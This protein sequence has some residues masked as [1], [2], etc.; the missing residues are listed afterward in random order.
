RAII[1]LG[2]D[3]YAQFQ[4]SMLGRDRF[5]PFTDLL[6][7]KGWASEDVTLNAFPARALRVIYCYHLAGGYRSSPSIAQ[8]LP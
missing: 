8:I 1:V 2:A 5:A 4:R 6:A 7:E 3:A